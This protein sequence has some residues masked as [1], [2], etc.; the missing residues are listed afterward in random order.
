MLL[1]STLGKLATV[2]AAAI[3]SVEAAPAA[4][5]RS[6]AKRDPPPKLPACATDSDKKWQ[7][8]MDFD[9]DSCYNSPAIGINGVLDPGLN[10]CYTTG[11]A[12]CR[13]EGDLDNNNVYVRARC[14]NG[15][16]AYIYGYYF[17]KDVNL[18]HVCGVGAGHR[19]DWE[20]VVVWV[21]NGTAKYVAASAHTKY[22]IR[23]IEDVLLDRDTHPKIV[24][25]RSGAQ[26]HSFRFSK[27]DDDRI[28]NHKGVWFYGD[29]VSYLGFSSTKLR[30]KMLNH[31][32]GAAKI[33]FKDSRI[34]HE[35]NKAKGGK[36]I[37]LDTTFDDRISL[38][39]PYCAGA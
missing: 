12:G 25:H 34:V 3:P 18:E 5:Y 19:N 14:N 2:V 31:N 39:V 37:P 23:P 7:P 4:R 24:Y 21:Q 32:W 27:V 11:P 8:A 33:D 36:D 1:L 9:T 30:D 16:C 38:R 13:D 6:I 17:E 10:N 28:E 26:T 15:W 29:L 35:L 22:H 20:H